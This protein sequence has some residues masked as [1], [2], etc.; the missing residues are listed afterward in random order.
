MKTIP[1]SRGMEVIVD[2]EDF[3]WLNQWKWC[4]SLGYARKSFYK[5][6][7]KTTIGMHRLILGD[8]DGKCVDHINGNKLDNR[9]ENLRYCSLT[10]NN[11]NLKTRK[12]NSSGYKG[13]YWHKKAAKW[14]CGIQVDKN[15]ISLGLYTNLLDAAYA[16]NQAAIKYFGEFASLNEL[17]VDFTPSE[18]NG[19]LIATNTS[20]YR[21]V[22]WFRETKKWTVKIKVN[23]KT[24][25]LGYYKNKED[26]ARVYNEAAIKYLGDRAKLNQIPT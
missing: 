18:R 23:N 15:H 9:R 13:I 7:K 26:A 22:T 14:F 2:D 19:S 5:N 16:Y 6:G 10:E 17:P 8:V 21:G 1:L 20:G 3:E 12:N 11:R 4:Y 24:I 25:N